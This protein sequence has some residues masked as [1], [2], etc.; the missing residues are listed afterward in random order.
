MTHYIKSR[1]LNQT[2]RF[3]KMG[4]SIFMET[5]KDS[6]QICDNG[7][8]TGNSILFFGDSDENFI[9]ICKNWYRKYINKIELF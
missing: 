1:K 4:N 2:I 3:Y 7:G 5:N 6:N 9:K 8:L